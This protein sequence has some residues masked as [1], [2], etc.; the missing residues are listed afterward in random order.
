ME[1]T[2]FTLLLL[3]ENGRKAIQKSPIGDGGMAHH[4]YGF[5]L[6]MWIPLKSSKKV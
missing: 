6:K 2:A 4:Q 1:T 3:G 5:R